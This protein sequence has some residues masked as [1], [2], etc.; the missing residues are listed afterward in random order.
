M[1]KWNNGGIVVD[2]PENMLHLKDSGRTTVC[3]DEC[4]VDQ[5]KALW[6]AGIETLGCCCGHHKER[7][8]LVVPEGYKD[9]DIEKIVAIL[10]ANDSRGWDIMQWRL[11]TVVKT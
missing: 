9:K 5:I 10:K 1:C 2:L 3:I 8:S 6:E 11:K 7:P 4:I